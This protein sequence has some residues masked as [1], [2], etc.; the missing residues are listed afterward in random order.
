MLLKRC[1]KTTNFKPTDDQDVIN[2]DH[3]DEKLFKI[4]GHLSS[5]EKIYNEFK[6]HY[7]KQSVE[8]V[9]VQR[10]VKTTI[11]ILCDKS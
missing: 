5:L 2:K 6:L 3:L 10:P 1:K 9:L 7:N 11:Q 8:E 4:N